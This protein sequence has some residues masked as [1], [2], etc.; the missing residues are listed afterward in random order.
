MP[1]SILQKIGKENRNHLFSKRP[2]TAQETIPVIEFFKD[3]I[4]EIE[5]NNKDTRKFSK[6]W[7]FT[8][9][10]YSDLADDMKRATFEQYGEILNSLDNNSITKIT[11]NNRLLNKE[12]FR[13]SI[14]MP[15]END[16]YDHFRQDYNMMLEEKAN[17]SNGVVQDKYI[18]VTVDR[19]DIQEARLFFNR[20]N[21]ELSGQFAKI[22]S[23]LKELTLSERLAIFYSFYHPDDDS[24]VPYD[25]EME[26]GL[27]HNPKD[28]IAPDG[29]GYNDGYLKIGNRYA[30]ALYLRQYASW[31][32]DDFVTRL[33]DINKN[34]VLSVDV[35]PIPADEAIREA[36]NRRLSVEANI[37]A[38]QR[39]QN[40]QNNFAA[41]IPY[42]MQQ[43]RDETKEYLNDLT[44]RDQRMMLSCLTM[45]ITAPSL[46]QLEQDTED[47]MATVRAAMCQF[48]VMQMQ[49][50]EGLAAALP[51]G[52]NDKLDRINRTL[53][54]ES[55]SAFMPFNV[56]EIRH[57]GGIYYGQ[58]K[59]SKN[60]IIV[61][62][63]QLQ[64]G[65]SFILGVS[66]SGKSFTGKNEVI[67]ILL[68]NPNADVIVIDPEREYSKLAKEFDGSLIKISATSDTH[69]NAMD[70]NADYGE[71]A[72][73][74]TLKS[75][76]IMSLCA[77]IMGESYLG[78]K[79]KSIIDRCT[80]KVYAKYISKG[81]KGWIPDLKEL[82]REIERQREPEAQ[83]LAVA[84]E[85]FVDGSLNTFAQKTNV[86][87][88][89]RFIVYDILDLGEQLLPVGMLVVLDSILNRITANRAR[90]RQTYIFIDEIY[91]LFLNQYS[92]QFL[93]KLWKRVRKYNAMCTGI[94]Q[95]VE[96]LLRSDDAREMLGNSEFI[97]MLNQAPTDRFTL[98]QL[99]N[100]SE[101]QQKHI[102]GAETGSGLM[103]IG[104]TMVPFIN[105]FPRNSLY[106]LMHTDPK[107][108]EI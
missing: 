50:L 65:N 83:D 7:Q 58:N 35:I 29:I 63:K 45:V 62:R 79:E 90:G 87:T 5:S 71:G 105:R 39:K 26:M 102:T 37:T 61:D 75:E 6:C 17:D 81:Y 91:L 36:E 33:V 32:N 97:I 49:Q 95:N 86:D 15:I 3:G 60:L 80:N 53:T 103:K 48:G 72:N 67:N 96:D 64:N 9:I 54:T 98:A 89:N 92:S 82:K 43:Q 99:L 4:F 20:I 38:W 12:E 104:D 23:R 70:I 11:I 85:M 46:E 101:D 21:A 94:T 40:E 88:D 84:L 66:G 78:P 28:Y 47:I 31:L 34:L 69:I 16:Q 56:Q 77:Q 57:G 73:P 2:E 27:G 14:L 25:A 100:I 52:T 24:P 59:I 10:N 93:M 44:N 108:K 42:D 22:G 106:E 68:R 41:E 30:R 19:N 55:L 18:T 8:D 76:F 13:N 74:V 51:Y 107:E 1:I